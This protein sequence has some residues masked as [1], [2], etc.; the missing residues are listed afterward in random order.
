MEQCSNDCY[1][2]HL[3]GQDHISFLLL[4][5]ECY[6]PDIFVAVERLWTT[7]LFPTPTPRQIAHSLSGR[8]GP[9]L[10]SP[11]QSGSYRTTQDDAHDSVNRD[12][13]AV[14]LCCVELS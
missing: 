1:A 12:I 3:E 2:D 7:L 10:E 6:V 11:G 4:E 14:L 5:L 13:G 8:I 9:N